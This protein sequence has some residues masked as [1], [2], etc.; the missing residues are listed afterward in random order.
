MSQQSTRI[1]LSEVIAENFGANATYV[2]GLLNRFRS[3]PQS[4]DDSWRAYF[5]E[6]LG[7]SGASQ[8]DISENGRGSAVAAPAAETPR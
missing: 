5:T 6:L 1:D 3:N 8:P 7:D 4:V 2:E